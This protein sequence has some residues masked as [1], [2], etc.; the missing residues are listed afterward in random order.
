MKQVVKQDI[1]QEKAQALIA[2][3]RQKAKIDIKA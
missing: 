2:Q 3:L 1:L